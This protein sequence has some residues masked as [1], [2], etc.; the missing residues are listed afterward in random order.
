[1]IPHIMFIHNFL[2]DARIGSE[3]LKDKARKEYSDALKMP[4]KKKKKA[5]K[6]AILLFNIACWSDNNFTF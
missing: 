1:M 6:S 5:K 2:E 4:R 3:K